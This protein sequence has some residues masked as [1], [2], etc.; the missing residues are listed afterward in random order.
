MKK[1]KMIV[2][3]FT[4]LD[5]GLTGRAIP[6]NIELPL[7]IW[8]EYD[9]DEEKEVIEGFKQLALDLID[10]DG[11]VFTHEEIDVEN[12][13]WED[14]YR[15]KTHQAEADFTEPCCLGSEIP[16]YGHS[17]NCKGGSK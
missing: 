6:F 11:Q 4:D 10:P 5:V 12:Q 7:E 15:E 17:R 13:M 2:E 9:E 3:T 14:M 16:D 8:N 1:I